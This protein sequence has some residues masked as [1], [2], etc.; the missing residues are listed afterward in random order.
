MKRIV[1]CFLWLVFGTSSA[2][3]QTFVEQAA[4]IG[5]DH[6]YKARDLTGGGAAFFDYDNDGDEDLY[7]TG[8]YDKDNFYVN[9]GDGTF[10]K[11]LNDMGFNITQ[12]FNTMAVTTGD[13][14]ND[15]DRDIMVTTWEKFDGVNQPMGRNLLFLN[16]GNGSFT[17]IGEQ[18]GIVHTAFSMAAS[19][20]DYDR[21]GYLDIYVMNHIESPAFTFDSTGTIDGYAH[22][23]FHNFFYKNNGD[24]TF[25]EVAA[26]MAVDNNGCTIAALGT[27]YDMDGDLDIYMANDFGGF[28]VPN[29]MYENNY[30]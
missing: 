19:F 5:I 11:S 22:T 18:A 8:G 29:T 1:I 15:G 25:T 7:I 28:I 23:C 27:D 17:E 24:L 2:F 6:T 9:N 14:D 20:L 30:P 4:A 21:D 12:T 10:T 16:D 13:I 26:D 3:A